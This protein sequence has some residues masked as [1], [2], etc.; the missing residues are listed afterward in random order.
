MAGVDVATRPLHVPRLGD[1]LCEE[2]KT[3]DEV[4][5]EP[6]DQSP[7][8]TL[9]NLRDETA[10]VAAE[11]QEHAPLKRPVHRPSQMEKR[12][13]PMRPQQRVFQ[14]KQQRQQR[15]HRRSLDKAASFFLQTGFQR[16]H[17]DSNNNANTD[18]DVSENH[19]LNRSNIFSHTSKTEAMH[20]RQDLVEP[21][22][23]ASP[24]MPAMSQGGHRRVRSTEL[25][26]S[27]TSFFDTDD[28]ND[29][30]AASVAAKT[31][32]GPDSR[33]TNNDD[34]DDDIASTRKLMCT[35]DI[36]GGNRTTGTHLEPPKPV[37]GADKCV[38][39]SPALTGGLKRPRSN[40]TLSSTTADVKSQD[41]PSAAPRL[42]ATRKRARLVR[43]DARSAP[44]TW[45][46]AEQKASMLFL[47][48]IQTRLRDLMPKT[49]ALPDSP[50]SST[51]SQ[52]SSSSEG[53]SSP[54]SGL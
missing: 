1:D 53:P 42:G 23:G 3:H 36:G 13:H 8:P 25:Q 46:A 2:A 49:R 29:F 33:R 40:L 38:F 54:G 45:N 16:R 20:M 26:C 52:S 17:N 9:I 11:H 35:M 18:K 51:S 48:H 47:Q 34:D 32:T 39:K 24:S 4:D 15:Q 50:L 10:K 44:C 41:Q 5:G 21:A 30:S 6:R 12:R 28:A 31:L 22:P 19:N 37:V 7:A 27:G 43:R 14:E